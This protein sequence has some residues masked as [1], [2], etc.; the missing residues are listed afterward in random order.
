VKYLTALLI[1]GVLGCGLLGCSGPGSVQSKGTIQVDY[2]ATGS[3]FGGAGDDLATGAQVV[4]LNPAGDVIASAPL[5]LANTVT[6]PG[7]SAA[8]GDFQDTLTWSVSVPGGL[9]SYGVRIGSHGTQWYSATGIKNPTL[10]LDE[11]TD[12]T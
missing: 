8:S 3:F 12:G 9:S 4:I 2:T 5:N 10:S 1:F 6:M 11:T 7:E